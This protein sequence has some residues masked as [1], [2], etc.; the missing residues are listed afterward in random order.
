MLAHVPETS[1]RDRQELA[2]R[3]SFHRALGAV[4]GQGSQEVEENLKQALE[5]ARKV[6]D[7]QALV[8]TM[9]AL[10]RVYVTRSDRAGALQI[11]EEDSRLVERVHDPALAILLHMQLGRFTPSVLNMPKHVRIRRRC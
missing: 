1:E 11:A 8:T 4:R 10:G 7:E 6:N 3:M 5:L 2:L 9:V